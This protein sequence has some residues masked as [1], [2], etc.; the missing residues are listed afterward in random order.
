MFKK[1]L[2]CLLG[3]IWLSFTLLSSRQ[4]A[5]AAAQPKPILLVYDALNVSSGGNVK[6]DALQRL[7]TSLNVSVVTKRQADYHHQNLN[8]RYQAV[9]TMVNWPASGITNRSFKEDRQAFTGPKLHIGPNLT[10]AERSE[11]QAKTTKLY[12]QQLVLTAPGQ[13]QLLPFASTLEVV[14]PDPQNTDHSV[15]SLQ[16]QAKAV[17]TYAYGWL[18]KGSAYLPNFEPSGLSLVLAGRLFSQWLGQNQTYAP[19]LTLTGVTPYSNLQQLKAFSRYCKTQG[20]PF[21]VSAVSVADNM[22][23]AAFTHYAAALRLVLQSGGYLWLKMPEPRL[24]TPLEGNQLKQHVTS[25]LTGLAQQSV[26]PLGFSAAGFWNQDQSLQQALNLSTDWLLLPNPSKSVAGPVAGHSIVAN[27]SYFAAALSGFNTLKQVQNQTFPLPL[28]TT[29][30]LPRSKQGL[31]RLEKQISARQW[32]WQDPGKAAETPEIQTQALSLSFHKGQYW[33]NGQAAQI[34]KPQQR[35]RLPGAGGAKQPGLFASYFRI[36]GN[37]LM[38]FFAVVFVVLI[39]FIVVGR[40]I[41]WARF[42]R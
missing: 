41:Y 11:L 22:N 42:K 3:L 28:A 20:I 27:R 40:R 38:I 10:G 16:T 15:G 34:Q 25:A 39:S 17:P 36:Q 1:K 5:L 7:L 14:Q 26:Y 18:Q 8:V 23:M 32:H 4:N 6:L 37:V 29:V 13:Q 35:L 19:L 12:A 33:L 9:V 31:V 24:Q 21:A 2:W 30:P